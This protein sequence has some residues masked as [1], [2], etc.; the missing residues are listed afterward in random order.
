MALDAPVAAIDCGTNST[1]LLVADPA[2]R[3]LERLMRITRLGEGVDAT[4]VLSTEAMDRC[5]AVLKEYRQVMDGFGVVRGRAVATSAARD[6][7]N[8]GEFLDA[9]QDVTGVRPELLAGT[10]EG[11]LSLAGAVAE[12][13]PSDGP[14]LVLDIGGGSTELVAGS[15]SHD[16]ELAVVSLQM[17]CV[18]LTERFFRSDPPEPAELE[19]AEAEVSRLLDAAIAA[20]PALSAAHRLV[21]LAGTITTLAAVHQ[22][23][24]DYD[25]DRIH[26]SVMSAA[27]VDGVVRDSGVGGQQG[28]TRACRDGARPRRRDRRRRADPGCRDAE[29]RLRGVPGF[30]GGHPRRPGREHA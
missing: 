6:A 24:A 30:R 11:R 1:R 4:G 3:P 9:V 28:P 17:G 29:V 15:G 27:D 13:D 8:G 7:A 23:L 25:R 21:G 10:E 19:V 14:F 5:L 12:L 26:H 16:P 18:R 2:G 22:G 20:H